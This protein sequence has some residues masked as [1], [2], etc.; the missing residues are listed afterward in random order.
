MV[1]IPTYNS[2]DCSNATLVPVIASY[3]S[4]G[5][6]APLYVR[7]NGEAYKILSYYRIDILTFPTF[8]CKIEIFGRCRD[9][10]LTYHPKDYVWTLKNPS[11]D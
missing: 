3:D 8:N 6:I 9:I 10:K 4:L 2:Y 7:I 5:N 1:A 11:A